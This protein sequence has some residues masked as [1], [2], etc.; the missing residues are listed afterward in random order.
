M[1]SR[2]HRGVAVAPQLTHSRPSA[3]GRGTQGHTGQPAAG[4]CGLLVPAGL[5]RDQEVG[6][7]GQLMAGR[8]AGPRFC[9]GHQLEPGRRLGPFESLSSPP[10]P[11]SPAAPASPGSLSRA[12]SFCS[13]SPVLGHFRL[14]PQPPVPS[15]KALDWDGSCCC[16]KRSKYSALSFLG[17]AG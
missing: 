1:P 8:G 11:L 17:R 4:A 3:R 9:S 14:S 12:L 6:F 13:P 15:A 16:F 5:E 10:R 7:R 2:R